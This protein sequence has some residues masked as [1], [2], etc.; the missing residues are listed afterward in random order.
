MGDD[1][2]WRNIVSINAF[3]T[4]AAPSW[5]WEYA[6]SR[7]LGPW[8]PEIKESVAP[9]EPKEFRIKPRRMEKI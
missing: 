3:P 8:P 2:P 7:G 9:P 1:S 5:A 4:V 6:G